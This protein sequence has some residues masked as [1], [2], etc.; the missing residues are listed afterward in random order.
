MDL[1]FS[2]YRSSEVEMPHRTKQI[3]GPPVYFVGLCQWFDL[4]SSFAGAALS[5]PDTM[6]VAELRPPARRVCEL[7][8]LVRSTNT[9]R[10]GCCQKQREN[11]E[12]HPENRRLTLCSFRTKYTCNQYLHDEVEFLRSSACFH[13]VDWWRVLWFDVGTPIKLQVV[14]GRISNSTTYP[15][16][17]SYSVVECSDVMTSVSGFMVTSWYDTTSDTRFTPYILYV[18]MNISWFI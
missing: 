5:I 9:Y 15:G 13:V 18:D 16:T 10:S 14:R 12:M 11:V 6:T 7:W 3:N 17:F 1:L 4:V 8:L 2:R